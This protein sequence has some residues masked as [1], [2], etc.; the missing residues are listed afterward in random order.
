MKQNSS[1]KLVHSL[2]GGVL[3]LSLGACT[4]SVGSSNGA[5]ADTS[6]PGSGGK[7]GGAAVA[8]GSGGGGGVS[9]PV[10]VTA[11]SELRR[12]TRAE[13]TNT[14]YDLLGV[15][16][17]ADDRPKELVIQ[18]HSEIAAGQ[19]IGYE[20]SSQYLN[21]GD[22]VAS[23]AAAKID[24]DMKCADAACY[25]SWATGFLLRAF[26]EP[27]A[28]ALLDRYTAIL[29]STAAGATQVERVT[30]F[31]NALLVSPHFLYRKELGT[32]AV[33]GD[34]TAKNMNAYHVASRL[35]Y[36]V[37]QSMP[38]A[39]LFA[40]AEKK[41]LLDPT[42][43]KT[44]LERM[45][46]DKR[47]QK[48]LRAFVADW[49]GLFDNNLGKKATAVLTGTPSDLPQQAARAFDM[50]VDEV[51]TTGANPRF[52]DL[53]K[54]DQVFANAA[55]SSVLGVTAT[56]TDLQKVQL[57][58]KDRLGI[59]TN[60][61][62]IAAHTKESGASPFPIGKFVYEN[63]LCEQIPSPPASVPKVEEEAALATTLRQK[64]E[65]ITKDQPC[66]SCHERIGPPGFAFLPFDPVGRFKNSD[67]KGRPYDTAGSLLF[68]GS[69]PMPFSSA[70]DLST[71]LAARPEIQKCI[72]R[73]MFRW[74]YGRFEADIDEAGLKTIENTAVTSGTGVAETLQK[75]VSAPIFGQVR[76]R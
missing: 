30:A 4:G 24:A 72:S 76:V 51:L 48:G 70:A 6:L 2:C 20:D 41:T 63:L 58:S 27:P 52:S 71:K 38:D 75:I 32:T 5:G 23:S 50:L 1:V 28:A 18:G 65:S 15:D 22:K 66:A 36:L 67:A 55:L 74:A 8:Q 13:Y 59:L 40:A 60:P 17:S 16:L 43:R 31:L 19:K 69:A 53:L 21:L 7:G 62:V 44:E 14:V 34:A 3:A 61:L 56:G 73:R 57:P 33:S 42:V 46:K 64:L 45:L 26:R 29:S 49:M 9:A 54:T 37:W 25:K 12:L 47:A 39:T 68:E 35:S 11:S 10:D